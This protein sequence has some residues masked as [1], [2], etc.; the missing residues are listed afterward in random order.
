MGHACRELLSAGRH[1]EFL[2]Y[3][4]VLLID[5]LGFQLF[6][7]SPSRRCEENSPD[8]KYAYG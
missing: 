6:S 4:S 7:R 3:C 8:S 2:A 5:L 1:L